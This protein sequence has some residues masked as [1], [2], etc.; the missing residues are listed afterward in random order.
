LRPVRQKALV[1]RP[2]LITLLVA[3]IAS[4]AVGGAVYA[5]LEGADRGVPPIDSASTFEIDDIQVDVIADNGA[6]AREEGWRQA[7]AKGWKA[8]WAKTHGR[9]LSEAPGLSPSALDGMVSGIIVQQEQIGPKRYIATLGI[10]FDRARTGQLLGV[11]G[12]VRRSAP[13]LVIPVMLTGSSYQ[14]FES[15]NEWQKAWARFRTGG[16]PIDYV[17]PVGNGVDPLLLNAAQT[18]RPGR[19]W[20]RMLLDQYGAADVIMPEVHLQ[21]S[22]PGG[23]A[24]ATFTARHGP[25]NRSLGTFALRVD[26]SAAIPRMLDEGIQRLDTLYAQALGVGL[27]RPDPTLVIEA[28]PPV[29]ALEAPT[30]EEPTLPVELGPTAP[31]A[32]TTTFALQVDTPSPA[33]VDRAELSVS[34]IDRVTSA[35]TTSLALGGTSVM[36]VTYM[37]DS[38]AFRAALEAQGWTVRGSGTNLR[39]SRGGD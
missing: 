6:K 35:I 22:F 23:P 15:R 36:R 20:W 27:L 32:A 19:G 2:G 14:S 29:E 28:P 34:R 18:H 33:S 10:L 17:R 37:G 9:P 13:M 38:D 30:E 21:R 24:V 8:L 11:S 39:I 16:S 7:Q 31:A 5:Q 3:L 4:L 1:Q 25:D 12:S 26:N